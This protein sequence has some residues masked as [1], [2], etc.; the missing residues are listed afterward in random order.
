MQM[1][2]RMTISDAAHKCIAAYVC[3]CSSGSTIRAFVG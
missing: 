1:A 3:V 2:R